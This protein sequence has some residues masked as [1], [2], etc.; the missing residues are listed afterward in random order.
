MALPNNGGNPLTNWAA[1]P[2]FGQ[3]AKE[4]TF[5]WEWSPQFCLQAVECLLLLLCGWLQIPI[6]FGAIIFGDESGKLASPYESK[7]PRLVV[8]NNSNLKV[9]NSPIWSTQKS[10]AVPRTT[11]YRIGFG[12]LENSL[13]G[14]SASRYSAIEDNAS[15]FACDYEARDAYPRDAKIAFIS[16]L[17]RWDFIP[18]IERGALC[19]S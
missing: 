19:N 11:G 13:F 15:N 2:F 18:G 4:H 12:R 7:R 16:Y 5:L 8:S 1:A 14:K 9:R 6:E 3:S 17:R 10:S